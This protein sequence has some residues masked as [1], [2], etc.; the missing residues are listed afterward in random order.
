MQFVKKTRARLSFLSLLVLLVAGCAST[1]N[2]EQMLTDAGFKRVLPQTPEQKRQLHAL[3]ADQLTVAHRNGKTYYV[4][5]DPARRQLY[6]GSPEQYQAYQQLLSDK[7]IAGEN[8]VDAD[9]AGASDLDEVRWVE[10]TG[11]GWVHGS[12]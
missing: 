7:A 9:M 11:D 4:F 5:P 1:R 2:T 3:P 12:Y 8:R 6:V 10:W